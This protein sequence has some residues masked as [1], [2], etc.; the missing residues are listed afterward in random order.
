MPLNYQKCVISFAFIGLA[1]AVQAASAGQLDNLAKAQSAYNRTDYRSAIESLS[2]ISAKPV[3]S[4]FLLGK[5]YYMLGEFKRACEFFHK[6]AELDANNSDSYLWLGRAYGRRAESSNPLT[7]PSYA[8]KARQNFEKSVNLNPKNGDALNDLFDYYLQAPGFLGGGL[9]KAAA[10]FPRI[11]EHDSAEFHFAQAQLAEKRK[12]FATAEQQLRRAL[13]L[14]PRQV[15]R[16]IDLAKFLLRRGR[17]PE[18]DALLKQAATIAP[19]DPKVLFEQAHALIASKRD[20]AEAKRLLKLYIK[21]PL[22]PELPSRIEA[23]K[24]LKQAENG[25]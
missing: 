1:A 14:A 16:V 2:G 13:D 25:A 19:N 12:E 7:A 15:G 8:S 24:L 23:E 11:K 21:S 9:D 20:L 10:M 6:A 17:I 3:E 18:S 4:N 5:S 22:T